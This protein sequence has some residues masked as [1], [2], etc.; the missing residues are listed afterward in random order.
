MYSIEVLEILYSQYT[1]ALTFQNLRASPRH[2]A[3]LEYRVHWSNHYAM[4]YSLYEITDF[5]EFTSAWSKTSS[6]HSMQCPH[7][8]TAVC[9][10]VTL[11]PSL[12]V[13]LSP[14]LSVC[15]P[16]FLPATFSPTCL[17][18]SLLPRCVLPA[19]SSAA[20]SLAP[21]L[22]SQDRMAV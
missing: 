2:A 6:L 10:S 11:P 20:A 18:A 17:P 7:V 8:T 15:P 21:P 14:S 3:G 22:H 1:K 5:S 4:V 9:L 19:S 13:S 12:S 16:V